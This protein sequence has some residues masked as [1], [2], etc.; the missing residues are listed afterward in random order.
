M[1]IE[2]SVR[3]VTVWHHKT[4]PHRTFMFDSFSYKPFDFLSFILKVAFITIRNDI[5]VGHS[6]FDVIV[7]S[8]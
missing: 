3:R 7:M 5:D 8:Q 4:L 6:E 1:R 2:T